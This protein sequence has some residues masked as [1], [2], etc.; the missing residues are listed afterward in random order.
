MS[1]MAQEIA[2]LMVVR[3][4]TQMMVKFTVSLMTNPQPML[5][6]LHPTISNIF[7]MNLIKMV[8]I[9]IV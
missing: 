7:E 3:I 4:Y 1:I 2:S 8:S 6:Q 5:I 9:K